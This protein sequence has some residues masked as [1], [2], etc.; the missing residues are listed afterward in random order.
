[1]HRRQGGDATDRLTLLG[2]NTW[3]PPGSSVGHGRAVLLS[4]TGQIPLALDRLPHDQRAVV[5][6]RY[7]LGLSESEIADALDCRPGTVKSRHARALRT[8]LKELP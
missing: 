5:V 2:Q 6:L 7:W 1:S 8:L 3:P 4:A